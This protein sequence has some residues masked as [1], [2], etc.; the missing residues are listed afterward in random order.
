MAGAGC[1]AVGVQ[2][3]EVE[4]NMAVGSPLGGFR[5]TFVDYAISQE[6]EVRRNFKDSKWDCGVRI[7]LYYN[8]YNF[9]KDI[10][11]YQTNRCFNIM[12]T[13]GYNFRQGS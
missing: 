13:G 11:D 6:L 3:Y 10:E 12:A 4:L 5:N 7:G 9:S 1:R 2:N 8:E